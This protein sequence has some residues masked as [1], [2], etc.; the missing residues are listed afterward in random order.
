MTK[1]KLFIL[2]AIAIFLAAPT[3]KAASL[4]IDADY[5]LR[6]VSYPNIDF[7]ASTSSDSLHYYSQRLILSVTG[8][9]A[10]GI[11][12]GAK[13]TSL[14]V[15]GSTS[16]I[17]SV[18][19]PKTDFT[20]YI[21]NA[22]IKAANFADIPLDI[23]IGR[24]SITYGD[25]LIISDN[26]TGFNAIRIAGRYEK[27]IPFEAELFT[28]KIKENFTPDT[29]FDLYGAV[30]SASWRTLL[31]EIGYFE[32]KDFSGSKYRQG[33]LEADTRAIVKQ[34][35]DF[36][37]G[38]KEKVASYQF[39]IAKQGGYVQ[40]LDRSSIKLDGISY[41]A[42]GELIGEKTKL[43]KVI[44]HAL[45]QVSSGDDNPT[46]LD[47]DDESFS[48][49]FTRRYDGLERKGYGDLFAATPM[50]SFFTIPSPY[51][52]INTLSIGTG[53]SP[54]YAWTFEATYFLYS[55][56]QGP[57]GAPAASGFERLFGAEFAM[58]VEL[59][60]TVKYVHSKYTETKFTF[61]RYTPPR[62]EVYWPK[63]EPAAR[64]QLE[65]SAKF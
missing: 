34:F 12:V 25:G 7:D 15:V 29:D 62:F 49:D 27:P 43:G 24:Q 16:T 37:I 55:A 65:F 52:G 40:K 61:S 20:P 46:S 35:Y 3:L 1:M 30:G 6:G 50:G 5:V 22:Y 56:S 17:F 11:E 63:N 9:P 45:L 14:G 39:E 41:T 58:G 13:I 36:R 47:D 38:K 44:A 59:D 54:L 57:K 18:P 42:Y 23:T 4:S 33:S 51:S 64:Y 2:P 8:K 31:W 48:P 10:Q 60:L 32:Q 53:F 26:G 28:A 21:E 19:F